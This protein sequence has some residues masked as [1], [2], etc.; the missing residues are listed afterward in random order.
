M[1]TTIICALTLLTLSA[2]AAPET[3]PENVSPRAE[4][5]YTTGSNLPRKIAKKDS[6]VQV[7]SPADAADMQG[8]TYR[9]AAKNN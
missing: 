4:A 7:I 5:S 6:S 3:E 1:K 8:F 9:P 2:C